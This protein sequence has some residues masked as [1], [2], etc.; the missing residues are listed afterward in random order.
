M[1]VR[2]RHALITLGLL[3]PLG[4]LASCGGALPSEEAATSADP[5]C[6]APTVVVDPRRSLAVTD[7]NIVNNARFSLQRVMQ[8]LVT[9]AGSSDT[10]LGVYKRL[11][12]TNNPAP[13]AVPGQACNDALDPAGNPAINNYQIDCGRQEGV[14]AG[15]GRDPFCTGP[16]CDPYIPIALFNRF[17][18]APASGAH[19]GEYRIIFG[20]RSA[21]APAAPG[22]RNLIIFEAQLPNPNPGCG[23]QACRPVAEFW[24]SLTGMQSPADRAAALERFYFTGL[25]GFAPVIRAA[26][27]TRATGQIRTNQFMNAI[28]GQ[29]WQLREYRL[30]PPAA[31]CSGAACA[32]GVA[33]VT[34]K[35]N[36]FAELFSPQNPRAEAVAFRDPANPIGFVSQVANLATNNINQFFMSI[37]DSFNGGESTSQPLA[38]PQTH[39]SDYPFWLTPGPSALRSAI[40][41]KLTA[42]GSPLTPQNIIDR[43]QAMSCAGCHQL[44]N[45]RNLGGGLV[46]PPSLVFTHVS[47]N[48]TE[49]CNGTAC[50]QISPALRDV[51]LPARK[52][53][54]E[55]FLSSSACLS[56][57]TPA[58]V[59]SSSA[60]LRS[61]DTAPLPRRVH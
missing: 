53:T 22:N 39:D 26:H 38:P 44:S 47:E 25:P 18:L 45:N 56:C 35:N 48:Q 9:S 59:G 13:G 21:A 61:A 14:L 4:L 58:A 55:S 32:L 11:F 3:S 10:P 17:D 49:P 54:L 43:A 42:L 23:L 20:K 46:W 30:T 52:A 12:D 16:G 27:Y 15:P 5:L 31:G 2:S 8:Q 29:P 1:K 19:C 51:F 28:A 24:A 57:A 33:M 40:Q 60:A 7:L 36:P 41:G 50:W 37:D 6:T 34:V